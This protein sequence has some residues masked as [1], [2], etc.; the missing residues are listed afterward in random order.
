M[1]L[2]TVMTLALTASWLLAID[3]CK[4]EQFPCFR[5]LACCGPEIGAPLQDN[6][7]ETDGCA[8]VE[9]GLYKSERTQSRLSA[10]IL[11]VAVI[12]DRSLREQAQ[13]RSV[14]SDFPTTDPPGFSAPWQF[15]VRAAAPPRAPSLVS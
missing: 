10:P 7:C 14:R 12:P 9:R 11:A 2:K 13:R 3:H 5:F 1:R 15:S 8:A 4:L 6:D